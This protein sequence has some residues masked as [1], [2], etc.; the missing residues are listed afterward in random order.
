MVH[1]FVCFDGTYICHQRLFIAVA[2][3]AKKLTNITFL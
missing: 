2:S 1:L 3:S